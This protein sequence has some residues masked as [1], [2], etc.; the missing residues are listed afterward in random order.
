M[1]IFVLIRFKT[2]FEIIQNRKEKNESKNVIKTIP[3]Y[4]LTKR[5]DKSSTFRLKIYKYRIQ[6]KSRRIAC[7]KS[8]YIRKKTDFPKTVVGIMKVII[9]HEVLELYTFKKILLFELNNHNLT[10]KK[11]KNFPNN[12]VIYL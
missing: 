2:R 7:R 12:N 11:N 3:N 1:V 5:V 6:Y 4:I 9:N 10:K 8:C